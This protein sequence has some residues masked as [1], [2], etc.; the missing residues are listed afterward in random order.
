MRSG[1]ASRPKVA[2]RPSSRSRCEALSASRR[3]SASRALSAAWSTSSRLRPRC[4]VDRRTLARARE[5][6]RLGDQRSRLD[7]VAQK[8]L[9][10]RQLVGVELGHEGGEDLGDGRVPLVAREI[11]AVAVVLTAAEEEHLDADLARLARRGDDI[12]VAHGAGIDALARLDLRQGTDAVAVEGGG[13]ELER[14]A[15]FLHAH[16]QPVLHVPAPAL[17]K[18]AGFVDQGSVVLS[19]DAADARRC[20][21]LDLVLQA[22]PGAAVEHAVGAGSQGEGPLQG[23]DG[24][25][26]RASRGERPEILTLGGARATVFRDLRPWMVAAQQDE[27]E[28]LVVSQNDVEPR[29]QLLDQVGF[30]EKRLH[31]G[32]GRHD[33]DGGGQPDHA[34]DTVRLRG[35]AGV[36]GES[37]PEVL[38]LADIEHLVVGA[39]H[40]VDART[41]RHVS[42]LGADDLGARSRIAGLRAQRER[43]PCG[44]LAPHGRL[45]DARLAACAR[46]PDTG[47]RAVS[48]GH[49]EGRSQRGAVRGSP[50]LAPHYPP[51]LWVTLW[52]SPAWLAPTGKIRSFSSNC[53]IVG[54]KI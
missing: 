26:D 42:Y 28:G 32:M 24:A 11:G 54:Q 27:G 17:E 20:A 7:V 37:L 1:A 53:P 51:L 10:G 22:G 38:G 49:G 5:P 30:E 14:G 35:R 23:V 50:R 29:S 19:P 21:A 47:A 44:R 39:E 18:R 25:V 40:P 31:L 48:A 41:G 9:P 16:R 13:L 4:G 2:A 46:R 12:G 15:G 43:L 3:L 52:K 6:E 45:G 8:Y 36:A 33:L 34:P